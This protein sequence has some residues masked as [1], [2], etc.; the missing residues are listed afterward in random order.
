MVHS[1]LTGEQVSFHL[2]KDDD[3]PTEFCGRPMTGRATAKWQ[4][5]QAH[6]GKKIVESLV[7]DTA[8]RALK[9]VDAQM[10]EQ[11]A[12]LCDRLDYI[13]N[14]FMGGSHRDRIEGEELKAYLE[15]LLTKQ[16]DQLIGTLQ[17]DKQLSELTFRDRA[18]PPPARGEETT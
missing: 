10:N 5:I 4:A 1:Y 2:P 7:D 14:A 16:R 3:N 12:F 17:D 8:D 13:G 11:L 6:A 9:V 18:V 15:G